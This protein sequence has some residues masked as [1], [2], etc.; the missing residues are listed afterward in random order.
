MKS[1]RT[2]LLINSIVQLYL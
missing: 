2:L 1:D